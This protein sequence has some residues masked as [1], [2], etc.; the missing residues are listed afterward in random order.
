MP[1][2]NKGDNG[3]LLVTLKIKFPDKLT[4]QQKDKLHQFFNK[5]SYW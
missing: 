5:R 4:Q 2:H 3:D 1:I